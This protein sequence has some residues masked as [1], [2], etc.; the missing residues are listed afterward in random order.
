MEL[1]VLETSNPSEFRAI[2]S[3]DLDIPEPSLPELYRLKKIRKH[4]ES[5]KVFL[6]FEEV[7]DFANFIAAEAQDND[8]LPERPSVQV[9]TFTLPFDA[10]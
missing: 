10:N 7:I 2:I 6:D 5:S 1:F 8:D 9:I 3:N 4:F